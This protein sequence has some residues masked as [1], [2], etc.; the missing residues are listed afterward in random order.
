MAYCFADIAGYQR[1]STYTGNNS[2]Y[3]EFVYTTSDGTATGTDG[4]EPA[5]LLVKR[6]TAG[7]TANWRIVDN[8]RS[9][10]NPR[11]IALFPNL[12]NAEDDDASQRVNFFTNGFQIANSD[13][14]WNASGETY[15]YLAIGSNP[16]PAP[17]QAN[18]FKALTYSGDSVS[19]RSVNGVGFLP[20]LTWIKNRD[21]TESHVLFD[22]LRYP[23]NIIHSNSSS[24]QFANTQSLQSFTGNGFILG[25]DGNV[26]SSSVDYISWNWKAAAIPTINNSGTITSVESL[27]ALAGFSIVNYVAIAGT[28]T[29][30]HNLGG[31]PEMIMQKSIASENWYVYFPPG[32]IDANYNYMILNEFDPIATTSSAAPTATTFNPVSTSGTYISYLFRSISTYQKIGTYTGQSTS[33]VTV[34]LDFTPSFVMV[35][36][37]SGNDYWTVWDTARSPSNNRQAILYWDLFEA[38]ANSASHY[39]QINT[40]EFVTNPGT[41]ANR[42]GNLYV[43]LAIK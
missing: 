7:Q 9:T 15:L 27:N 5:F 37:T 36:D 24:A 8:K 41:V 30:G 17:V 4:F 21:T 29:V 35:K 33:T 26:N 34:S 28:Q 20:Q 40:D 23:T 12:S 18:S 32:V 31:V 13:A 42:N 3:G 19:G 14:S 39:I 1:I 2:T 16:T 38:E 6:T 11:Q 10:Q 22:Q 25:N 43:Y